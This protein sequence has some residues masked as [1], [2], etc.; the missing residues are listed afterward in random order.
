MVLWYGALEWCC[1]MVSWYVGVV[2]WTSCGTVHP[3]E[4]T[5]YPSQCIFQYASFSPVMRLY[6]IYIYPSY[7]RFTSHI[8]VVCFDTP[9]MQP[10]GCVYDSVAGIPMI[11]LISLISSVIEGFLVNRMTRR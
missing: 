11:S 5:P 3:P 9:H 7:I 10:C 4:C 1:G 8:K 6:L 2:W